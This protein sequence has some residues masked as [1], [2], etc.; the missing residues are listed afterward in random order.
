[1]SMKNTLLLSSALCWL[2]AAPSALAQSAPRSSEDQTIVVTG[3][4]PE[5]DLDFAPAI[6]SRLGLSN[7]ET[8]AIVDVL[9]QND[10]QTQ[11]LNNAID[12]L[13]AAPGV[14][15]GN[16]PG[17]IG[18]GSLR[19]FTRGTNFQYDGVRTSTPG[20]EFRNWD[21]WSF[22]RVE[23]LK[24]PA[25]VLSGD[26]ALVGTINFVPK[27]PRLGETGVDVLASYGSHDT[28]R[29]AG[30]F[31]APLGEAAAARIDAVASQSDGWIDGANSQTLAVTAAWLW[32]PTERLSVRLSADHFEDEFSTAYYG[33]PLVPR[34]FARRP[35]DFATT[36]SG[37]VFDEALRET[38]FEA[39]DGIVE[40]D[41]TWLRARVDYKVSEAW[42]FRN[43]LSYYDG[44][45]NWQGSDVYTFNSAT[46][47]IDRSSTIITHG[48][49]VLFDRATF[50][51]DGELGGRR[52]RFT[53]GAEA[54]LTGFDSKRRFGTTTSVDAFNPD[55][56][57]FPTADTPAV[58]GTRQQVRADVDTIAIFAEDAFNV[59]PDLIL[60]GGARYDQIELD[61]SILN[62][63]SGALTTY[64][65]TYEPFSWRLGAVYSVRPSTQLFAQYS[66]AVVP[67]SGLLFISA[68]NSRFDLTT[69][70]NIE[71]GVKTDLFGERVQLTA[72]IYHIRQDDIITRDPSNPNVSIQ[73]GSQTSTGFETSVSAA[74]TDTLQLDIGAAFL[75]AEFDELL[76][77]GGANRSGNVPTNT[78]EQLVDFALTW[79]PTSVPLSFFGAVRYNGEFFM[80]NANTVRIAPATLFDAG[81]TWRTGVADISFRGR[82][83][84]DEL[85]AG[86]GFGNQVELGAPRS[87]ELTVT[88]SF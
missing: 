70:E 67:V 56:G 64:A 63:T 18:L 42:S 41:S 54:T 62:V 84:T 16:D 4:A 6:G 40:S 65:N 86:T 23:V 15:A 77:A 55:R 53:V 60:V 2:I 52:N 12:A 38:N 25:S 82:N 79:S 31:N 88:R 9:T 30:G 1:M 36:A 35:S 27:Q 11:G 75:N 47:L 43:D 87:V 51:Y 26:G 14:F 29:L 44:D 17:A 59:T 19:G 71:A 46:S 22:D 7:R 73:G 37:L 74:L 20:S 28:W 24:G 48:Q 85:H 3:R 68:A 69:G 83:L 33:T 72:S 50:S 21:S 80:D 45:R 34:A 8:P 58:F 13:N 81:V 32:K 10:F 5:R 78:P 57:L 49:E 61:R 76:E 39:N 66:S